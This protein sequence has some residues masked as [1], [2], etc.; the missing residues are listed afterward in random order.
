MIIF[1]PSVIGGAPL[2][3]PAVTYT[4]RYS[5]SAGQQ[6]YTDVDF[7]AVEKGRNVRSI[8]GVIQYYRDG[9]SISGSVSSASIGGVTA[10]VLW[11]VGVQH[12]GG[13]GT[14]WAVISADVPAGTSGTISWDDNISNTLFPVLSVFRAVNMNIATITNNSA[15]TGAGSGLVVSR[16]PSCVANGVIFAQGLWDV[17]STQRT[18][19]LGGL[20][21]RFDA[22][23]GFFGIK[24]GMEQFS[25][26]QTNRTVSLTLSGSSSSNIIGLNLMAFSLAPL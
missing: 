2:L 7:G 8:I 3:A 12:P 17:L 6:S 13:T 19:T 14:R 23:T 11:N 25:T 10:N 16:T 22:P 4:T 9:G 5:G 15:A 1:S 24:I 26:A 21:A 18:C 20:T